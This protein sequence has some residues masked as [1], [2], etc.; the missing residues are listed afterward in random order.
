MKYKLKENVSQSKLCENGYIVVSKNG[1]PYY[2]HKKLSSCCDGVV[3]N[4]G[5]TGDKRLGNIR[6]IMHI[7]IDME[8]KPEHIQD[9]INDELVEISVAEV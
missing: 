8:L 1:L 5:V 6:D 7:D 2:A 3:I 4:L 9:L